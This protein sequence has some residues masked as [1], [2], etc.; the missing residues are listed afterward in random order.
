MLLCSQPDTVHGFLL[1]E[2]Q[3]STP[4]VE[5]SSTEDNP[6]Q[7]HHLCYSGLQKKGAATSPASTE[8][9]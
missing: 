7:D 8:A 2:T 5:G 9:L 4:L 6:K 1:R 3:I